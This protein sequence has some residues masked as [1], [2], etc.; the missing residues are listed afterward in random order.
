MLLLCI[1]TKCPM[2][3]GMVIADITI[4]AITLLIVLGGRA[5][6]YVAQIGILSN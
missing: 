5:G 6:S 1:A 2:L 3:L 4:K